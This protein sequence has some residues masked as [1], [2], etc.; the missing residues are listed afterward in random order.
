MEAVC[1]GATKRA[2]ARYVTRAGPEPAVTH[3]G[4]MRTLI[5]IVRDRDQSV[6]EEDITDV[7][8]RYSI[9]RA[10]S[11]L[12]DRVRAAHPKTQL[13]DFTIKVARADGAA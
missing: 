4:M 7:T 10:I 12:L 11:D 1:C 6:L 2:I 9:G 5:R 3:G 13:S 8:E